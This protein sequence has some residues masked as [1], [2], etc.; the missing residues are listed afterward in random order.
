[1]KEAQEDKQPKCKESNEEVKR[2]DDDGKYVTSF[3][4]F[5]KIDIYFSCIRRM[6]LSSWQLACPMFTSYITKTAGNFKNGWIEY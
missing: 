1:M 3:S 4:I 6:I 2:D 5:I